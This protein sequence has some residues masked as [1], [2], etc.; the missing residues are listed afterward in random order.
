VRDCS[1]NGETEEFKKWQLESEKLLYLVKELLASFYE[2]R[3]VS[4]N[5]RIKTSAEGIEDF[6]EGSFVL[7]NGGSDYR[8]ITNEKLSP[9]ETKE[10]MARILDYRKEMMEF[11]EFLK[12]QFFIGG[13]SYIT[14]KRKIAQ[15]KIDVENLESIRS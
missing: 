12:G 2:K 13:E 10:L 4:E 14:E 6:M 9:E 5:I 3:E 1:Q 11:S 15:E 8:V 7:F